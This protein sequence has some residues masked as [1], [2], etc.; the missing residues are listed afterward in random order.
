MMIVFL[1][2]RLIQL[3]TQADPVSGK[4]RLAKALV[5]AK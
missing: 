5:S 3:L 2:F 1:A 4:Y